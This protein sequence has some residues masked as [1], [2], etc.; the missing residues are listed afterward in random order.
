M[1]PRSPDV[2]ALKS[3]LAAAAG[4]DSNT[5]RITIQT[6]EEDPE[7]GIETDVVGFGWSDR[8]G[9]LRG[10]A[11]GEAITSRNAKAVGHADPG[12]IAFTS[13]HSQASRNGGCPDQAHGCKT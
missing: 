11:R 9:W 1:T 7:N 4:H 13:P 10:A 12:S 6:R 5:P 8:V 3:G 2:G